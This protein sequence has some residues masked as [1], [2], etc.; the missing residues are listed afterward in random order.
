MLKTTGVCRKP[1]VPPAQPSRG[2]AVRCALSASLHKDGTFPAT[3]QHSRRQG[4]C[5]A[6]DFHHGRGTCSLRSKRSRGPAMTRECN[7]SGFRAAILSGCPSIPGRHF[8]QCPI[9]GPISYGGRHD[10]R[11]RQ[12][13]LARENIPDNTFV[14]RAQHLRLARM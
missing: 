6:S 12:T 3:K 9:S 5:M 1:V 7:W 10:R 13:P 11:R 14:S 8:S 2:Q 4:N